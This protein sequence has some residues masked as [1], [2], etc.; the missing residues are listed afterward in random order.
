MINTENYHQKI[1]SF[2]K[3]LF[4]DE[5]E[6]VNTFASDLFKKR[7]I[8]TRAYLKIILS[9]YLKI[10][11]EK[12]YLKYNSKGKPELDTLLFDIQFNLSHKNNY[13][14]YSFSKHTIGIDLEKIDH[15]TKVEKIAERFFCKNEFD[16]LK[17]LDLREKEDYFFKLWTKKEAYLKAIGEGLSG[18]LDSICFFNN[19]S[20]PKMNLI[21]DNNINYNWYFKTWILADDYIMSIAINS[22]IK[23]KFYYYSE[24]GIIDN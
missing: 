16:Y 6:K 2:Y 3:I 20:K 4:D 21:Q 9:R 24:L 22:P 12:I 1:D 14:I 13:I 5:Q 17:Q 18:G 8:I 11:P 15:K 19:K 23:P 7:F 10:K